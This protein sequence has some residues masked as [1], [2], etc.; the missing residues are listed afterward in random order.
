MLL[1][2]PSAGNNSIALSD[3]P[4]Q[5]TAV[6]EFLRSQG[7]GS[8][9]GTPT[10]DT[11]LPADVTG[12]AA[13][14]RKFLRSL[15]SGAA[16]GTTVWDTVGAAD[17][18][19]GTFPAGTFAYQGLLDL[20]NASAGQI[21]FPA[22][23]H[24]SANPT[25]LDDYEEGTWTPVI[26]GATST[27]GQSYFSQAGTYTKIGRRAGV[28]FYAELTAAGTIVGAAQ[29]QGLPFVSLNEVNFVIGRWNIGATVVMIAA[30]IQGGTS[31]I[32]LFKVTGAAAS[33]GA[34]FVASA[35]ITNTSI[36]SGFVA[37]DT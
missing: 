2:K 4:G 32:R 9:A 3:I 10:W 35:D 20:S 7:T 5:T 21:K 27:S 11:I 24:L 18:A 34:A 16:P 37:Y 8:V 26:G 15:G 23:P 17:V 13:A 1:D 31:L 19:A 12:D 22:T 33:S 28:Q 30:N 14:T 29:I 25:T 36:I 6:R